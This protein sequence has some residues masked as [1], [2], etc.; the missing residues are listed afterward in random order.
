VETHI[1]T[2]DFQQHFKLIFQFFNQFLMMYSLSLHYKEKR[3]KSVGKCSRP[4]ILLGWQ[5]S[6]WQLS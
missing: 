4:T 2:S 3:E 5:L 6:E 1:K